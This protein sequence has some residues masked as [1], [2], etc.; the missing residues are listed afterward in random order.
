MKSFEN[1]FMNKQYDRVKQ[2]GDKLAEIDPLIDWEAFRP[3]IRD[4]YYNQSERGGRPNNDE[5]VMIKMLVL[6]SW[7]GLSDPELERQAND[8]ISFQ[9]FLG[10]PERIPDR[11]TVWAFRERLIDTGKDEYI[12]KELQ[13]QIDSKG[14]KVKEGVIQDATFITADPGHQRVNEPRGPEAKTR[15]NKEGE[16]SKKGGKSYFGYKLHTLADKDY[17][18]IRR[19]ETTTAE[20]HDSQIDLSK[21]GEVVY[22]DRGYFG[23]ACKGYDATMKRAVRAHPLGIRDKNRNKRITRKRSAGERPY[24]VIKNIFKSG[25]HLV[26]TTLRVHTKNLFSCFCYNL[27]QLKT[28]QKINTT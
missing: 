15:R 8:R 20:I 22:R 24:A 17:D 27:L 14:L 25:H 26:T 9:K 12:W 23:A 10:F 7:Y 2:L 4:M 5:I 1:Y 3:V 13:R 21:P 11:S 28:L 19:L 16:W 18:L 6:Q